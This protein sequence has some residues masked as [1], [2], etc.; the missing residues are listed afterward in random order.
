LQAVLLRYLQ[1]I[2][3]SKK[4]KQQTSENATVLTTIAVDKSATKDLATAEDRPVQVF[5]TSHSPNFASIAKLSSLVCLVEAD[6]GVS[7]FLPGS[8]NFDKGKLS[9][10]ERY[11]DVTR[12]EL[13]FARRI[14]FV[15]GAAEMM[16]LSVLAEKCGHNL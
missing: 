16:L 12:A 8:V 1:S 7:C 10:L 6:K 4:G 14:I 5:V 9:K 15:E 13:F 11:L 2:K 3:T